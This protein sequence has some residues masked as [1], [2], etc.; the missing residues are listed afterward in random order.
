MT[1]EHDNLGD[2]LDSVVIPALY[3][4]LGSAFPEFRFERTRGNWTAAAWPDDFP[5][6]VED[7]R[8]GRLRCH[9]R[10]PYFLN[11]HGHHGMTWTAYV[12]HGRQ[13]SGPEYVDVVRE[14]CTRAGVDFPERELTEEEKEEARK[15]EARRAILEITIAH[16]REALDTD[17]GKHAREYL[18]G[19]GLDGDA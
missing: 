17:A 2:F 7:K 3:D 5:Y 16:A 13:P 18:H 14:L 9:E 1:N 6:P 10:H 8:P 4:R 12:N 15:R 11:I 19:K